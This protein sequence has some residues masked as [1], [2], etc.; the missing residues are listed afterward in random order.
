MADTTN[1]AQE[2]FNERNKSEKTQ[3]DTL[4]E[5]KDAILLS[6][7]QQ[8]KFALR[9]ERF[10]ELQLQIQEEELTLRKM[11]V[12]RNRFSRLKAG[13]A[14]AAGAGVA[15]FG[16]GKKMVEFD[17][18]RQKASASI[19]FAEMIAAGAISAI[20][21][22][23][24][25]TAMF[26][27]LFNSVSEETKQL[28]RTAAAAIKA[29]EALKG[30]KLIGKGASALKASVTGPGVGIKQ[31]AKNLA[32]GIAK[33]QF[34]KLVTSQINSV[35]ST[36]S[37]IADQAKIASG[38][39]VK[40]G[41]SGIAQT[42]LGGTDEAAMAGSKVSQATGILG[43]AKALGSGAVGLGKG[44]V[45]QGVKGTAKALG[46]GL[47]KGGASA[48]MALGKGALKGGGKL[49]G[50]SLAKIG[51][52][53][54]SKF[55]PGLGAVFSLYSGIDRWKK[56]DKV[57]A[58][59]DFGSAVANLIPGLGGFLSLGLDMINMARDFTSMPKEKQA[60]VMAKGKSVARHIPGLGLGISI[61][62][63]VKMFASGNILGGL[64]E[65]GGGIASTMPGGRWVFDLGVDLIESLSSGNEPKSS[66]GKATK[67]YMSGNVNQQKKALAFAAGG[68]KEL[69][70]GNIMSGIEL[71]L[72][73]FGEQI[74]SLPGIGDIAEG[75]VS[76][77]GFDLSAGGNAAMKKAGYDSMLPKK[78][79]NSS[80]ITPKSNKASKANRATLGKLRKGIISGKAAGKDVSGMEAERDALVTQIKGGGT[81]N[82]P[83]TSVPGVNGT[84]NAPGTSVPIVN[85]TTNAPGTSVPGV[86]GINH[87]SVGVSDADMNG[88][89]WDKLGGRSKIE[90]AITSVWNAAGV[91]AQPVFTSGFRDPKK[92]KDLALAHPN[93]KHLTGMAFDIRGKDVPMNKRDAVAAGLN[94]AFRKSGYSIYPHGEGDYF[95]YH[96]Q[97]PAPSLGEAAATAKME[98]NDIHYAAD[99]AVL[100][101]P[102]VAGEAGPEAIIPLNDR[103]IGIIAEAMNH[104]FSISSATTA[105][106]PNATDDFKAFL[107][108]TFAKTLAS[109]IA[110]AGKRN[111]NT[112]IQPAQSI[113]VI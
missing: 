18:K 85:G 49:V 13:A 10:E 41:G 14:V 43:K 31:G 30:A 84:T 92:N 62:D 53:V 64:K 78:A 75:L 46:G 2:M 28:S 81:T 57:G 59:I 96:M 50:K 93:S 23:V 47:I 91:E 80:T 105:R 24:L 7:Q 76:F 102:I 83:G 48:G 112:Q 15:A 34:D 72:Y 97:W 69:G 90:N 87:T 27:K 89:K 82:A 58:F 113:K 35:K 77:T 68:F 54:A 63:S 3:E 17:K 61:A 70:K 94:K 29:P 39:F 20:I 45:A 98:K 44:A 56:D 52:K 111:T 6:T 107:V 37:F 101:R 100:N 22:G 71:L 12:N 106:S 1:K 36:Y 40:S 8:A 99:G 67:S 109:E 73:G 79:P 4:L 103:G 108:D 38:A 60:A 21:T 65:L 55:I 16:V 104:A 95:H 74:Y 42:L 25:G 51:G 5:I 33:K 110:R 88:V 32:K 66:A 86:N 11:E 19:V 9:A 26:K